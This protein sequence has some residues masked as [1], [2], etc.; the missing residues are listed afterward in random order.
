MDC[1]ISVIISTMKKIIKLLSISCTITFQSCIFHPDKSVFDIQ[2]ETDSA[3]YIFVTNLDTLPI[4]QK[5][6]LFDTLLINGKDSIVAPI[7]R[8]N[9]Y[10]FYVDF[11][12]NEG[13]LYF[14][15]F[16]KQE[17]DS[18]LLIFFIKEAVLKSNTWE[19]I[20]RK[21]KY[22][23]KIITKQQLIVKKCIIYGPR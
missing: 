9:A 3:I 4:S 12:N 8:I 15:D 7:N 17:K 1:K 5:L 2:N 10:S 16:C 18:T 21:K 6:N 14:E 23:K 20:C 13:S 22:T 19:S 11:K